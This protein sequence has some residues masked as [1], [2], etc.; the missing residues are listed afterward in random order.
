MPSVIIIVQI[1]QISSFF[2]V[3]KLTAVQK[4]DI[5]RTCIVK[6]CRYEQ[7]RKKTKLRK[8][9]NMRASREHRQLELSRSSQLG[10]SEA[11]S[12]LAVSRE[13]TAASVT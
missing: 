13:V 9:A 1:C 12:R 8:R 7:K 2:I 4:T 5:T 10:V 6:A 3:P 11:V